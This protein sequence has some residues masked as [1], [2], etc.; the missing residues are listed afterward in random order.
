MLI[1]EDIDIG[2]VVV[3]DIHK[4][5]YCTQLRLADAVELLA[6]LRRTQLSL[7]Y[8]G[9]GLEDPTD[10]IVDDVRVTHTLVGEFTPAAHVGDQHTPKGFVY[11]VQDAM[12]IEGLDDDQPGSNEN[13]SSL[14]LTQPQRAKNNVPAKAGLSN[15]PLSPDGLLCSMH[16]KSPCTPTHLRKG[17][18][19]G[20]W[21]ERTIAL[22][23]GLANPVGSVT[24]D[25]DSQ[26]NHSVGLGDS[27]CSAKGASM[28]DIDSGKDRSGPKSASRGILLGTPSASF[29]SDAVEGRGHMIVKKKT[30]T[31]DTSQD[32]VISR[33]SQKCDGRYRLYAYN[34]SV[35]PNHAQSVYYVF[36]SVSSYFSYIT[37]LFSFLFYRLEELVNT[38][39][40]EAGGAVC[41]SFDINFNNEFCTLDWKY[42]IQPLTFKYGELSNH[43]ME[44]VRTW[45]NPQLEDVKCHVCSPYL[46]PVLT[47]Y[48][49]LN[50]TD[51]FELFVEFIHNKYTTLPELD[52]TTLLVPYTCGRHWTL[53]VLG[54]Q[55]FYHFD[56]LANVAFHNDLKIR[57]RL[58]KLWAVRGGYTEQSVRWQNAQTPSVWIR[59]T[60]PQQNSGWACGYY[61][62]KN[63]MEY[64]EALRHNPN[65]LRE[66]SCDSVHRIT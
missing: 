58:A 18:S 52:I 28:K 25:M 56:S 53:F 44:W 15:G 54:D 12:R 45:L 30:V 47:G 19:E 27:L 57:M 34:L 46:V 9:L 21:F 37:E 13:S 43:M 23:S 59:P 64:T 63:I 33:T 10:D 7:V 8:S 5:S 42:D 66:V 17:S 20:P 50:S 49:Q 39:V 35:L 11:E 6:T 32:D 60:V 41:P 62:L 55:G 14:Q 61:V 24:R 4:K 48:C 36:A 31:I 22:S 3:G 51:R 65:T 1:R 2:Y 26:A 29:V 38:I 40:A 16:S